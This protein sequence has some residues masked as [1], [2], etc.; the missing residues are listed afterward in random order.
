[1]NESH[2]EIFG[3]QASDKKIAGKTNEKTLITI[4]SQLINKT[5]IYIGTIIY[6]TSV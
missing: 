3:S 6:P 5:T 4:S 1:V 2:E